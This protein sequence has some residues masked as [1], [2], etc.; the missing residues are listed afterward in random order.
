MPLLID[1]LA[2][3]REAF[4]LKYG[5]SLGNIETL[6][7]TAVDFLNRP[8][9]ILEPI[10]KLIYFLSV[11][12]LREFNE[13]LLLCSNRYGIG[14]LKILRPMYERV[15]TLMY[16]H[17]HPDLIQRFIDYSQVHWHKILKE[18]RVAAGHD[19]VMSEEQMAEIEARYQ[20]VK[21]TY[22]Q[23]ALQEM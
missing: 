8:Y 16:L 3:D 23:T 6:H 2:D 11:A 20:A 12:C 7:A 10:D 17:G 22:E 14:A 1:N 15:I 5:T 13:I 4:A 21:E 9:P 19:D 18:A